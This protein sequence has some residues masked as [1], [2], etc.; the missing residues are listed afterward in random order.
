[1]KIAISAKENQLNSPFECSLH[2]ANYYLVI[3]TDTTEHDKIK[4]ENQNKSEGISQ[5]NLKNIINYGIDVLISGKCDEQVVNTLFE[6]G[7]RL[8]H[9]WKGSVRDMV[10][11]Y[12][13][14]TLQAC[15]KSN[16]LFNRKKIYQKDIHL[17]RK[18]MT[19]IIAGFIPNG[20]TI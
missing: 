14:P 20:K 5:H 13:N 1:M 4:N 16:Y 6:N 11:V 15:A 9:G 18:K 7:V 12:T 17:N 2:D 19:E 10:D 8:Y 3:D